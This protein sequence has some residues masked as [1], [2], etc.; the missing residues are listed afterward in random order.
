[1]VVVAALLTLKEPSKLFGA[2]ESGPVDVN[3]IFARRQR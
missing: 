2:P 1:M 3:G